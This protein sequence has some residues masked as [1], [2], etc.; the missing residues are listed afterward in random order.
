MGFGLLGLGFWLMVAGLLW[1]LTYSRF[2]A[3]V[4]RTRSRQPVPTPRRPRHSRATRR[5]DESYDILE[6]V[7]AE[8]G[9]APESPSQPRGAVLLE[10]ERTEDESER[11]PG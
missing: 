5:T 3:A 6:V 11:P 10:E 7:E 4:G 2:S 9:P 1:A 8:E